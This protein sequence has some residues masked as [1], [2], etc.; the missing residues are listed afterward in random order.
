VFRHTPQQKALR[1]SQE[2]IIGGTMKIAIISDIH[3]HLQNLSKAVK[4][5]LA[6]DFFDLPGAKTPLII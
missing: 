5:L 4:P 6:A 2:G 3:D 1:P